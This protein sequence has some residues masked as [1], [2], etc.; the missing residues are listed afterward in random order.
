[1]SKRPPGTDSLDKKRKGESKKR[2]APDPGP[3]KG[4]FAKN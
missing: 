3:N 1:M 2:K 4:I